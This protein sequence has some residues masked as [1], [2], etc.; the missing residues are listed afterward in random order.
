MDPDDYIKAR[1][2]SAMAEKLEAG[3]PLAQLLWQRERDREKVDTPER[4]A[5]LEERLKQAASQIQHGAVKSAYERDLRGRMND[6]FWE[7]RQAERSTGK[8]WEGGK[9][10][11][12]GVTPPPK[13]TKIRGLG[14]LANIIDNPDLLERC[15]EDV[16]L[17]NWQDPDVAH[18]CE[19]I[20]DLFDSDQPL[21]RERIRDH[22]S[23]LGKSRA[24][25][26][27]KDYPPAAPLD[28]D[29]AEAREWLIALEQ[30]VESGEHED[31]GP[32]AVFDDATASADAWRL[33]HKKVAERRAMRARMN[34]AAEKADQN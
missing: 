31:G 29:G 11:V 13:T 9:A 7:L 25:E 21:D 28:P 33:R 30:F 17:A 18:I 15:A 27:L 34:E 8:K 24:A 2:R 5:G 14:F 23:S 20:L 6:Y 16:V 4:K 3:M 12:Q 19:A 26:L 22:L 32:A 1:G 10:R